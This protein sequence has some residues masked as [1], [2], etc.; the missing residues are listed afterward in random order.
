M[1][2]FYVFLKMIYCVSVL[3]RSTVCFSMFFLI[4]SMFMKFKFMQFKFKSM[5]MFMITLM[6][7]VDIGCFLY[8]Q[9][10]TLTS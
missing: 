9:Q 1:Q 8:P 7:R 5:F 3:L 4:K 10:P 2:D 6:L